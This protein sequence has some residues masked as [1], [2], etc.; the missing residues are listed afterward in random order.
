MRVISA[1]EVDAALTFPSLIDALRD[2]FRGA[3]VAPTRHHHRIARPDGE[4]T[5]LLMPAWDQG[6]GG[7]AGIKV[8][9][10]VPGNAARGRPSVVGSYLLLDGDSGE[11]R[12]VIDGPSLTAWRTAAASA[13]AS[14]YLA[15]QDARRMAMIG[16]GA[17]A[18]KLIAAH[19]AVRPI[20]EVAIWNRTAGRAETLAHAL[21]RP[22][23]RVAASPDLD[24]AV[25]GA[26]IISC[27]TMS[28]TPLVHGAALREGSHVD[29]V[30]AYSARMRETD[31]E[32]IRRAI[33][34]VD[35]RDGALAEAGDIVQAIASG[36][37]SESDIAGD[38]FDLC[39][40]AV[41]GRRTDKEIT[42]FKSVGA[43][44]EDLATAVL[45][46]ERLAS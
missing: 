27:A 5:L 20:D 33:V 10:V 44:I 42:L 31:D 36:A 12:A 25:D 14:T 9:S 30:G 39:R 15:R 34:H 35:T 6:G 32:A 28:T 21:D 37:I 40:G 16:A 29:L 3:M 1:A 4:A 41:P 22:G 13:L 26:D 45:V 2:A 46:Y 17:L 19:A 24:A 23:L 7:Y 8:V 43:A 11:P 18:P 38:L